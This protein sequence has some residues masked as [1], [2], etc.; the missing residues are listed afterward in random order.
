MPGQLLLRQLLCL[1]CAASQ[2]STARFEEVFVLGR[3]AC[4]LRGFALPLLESILC[5]LERVTALADF[6]HMVT[7]GGDTMSVAMTNCG[8]LG[9]VTDR[10]GYRYTEFDP[11]S[12]VAWP[13]MPAEFAALARE[14]AAQA[15]FAAFVPDACLINRYL[16]GSR[17]SL[18][19][20]K[21]EID[22]GAPIVSV[23]LGMPAVF[24]FGGMRRA[25]KAVRVPL[26]HGDTVVW[27]GEDRLR[28]H[29]VLPLKDA[30]HE[31]L[32]AQR[33]NLTFRKAG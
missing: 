15:G 10:R 18:H 19:Q 25:D 14:A 32:G 9:W 26:M 17:L 13:A 2:M 24:L 6:R 7:P 5:A 28:F 33:I 16:A 22:F 12:G 30:G 4:V 29:G 11:Q 3:Q 27:G 8:R 23:S 20:D 21:D 31:I 1:G